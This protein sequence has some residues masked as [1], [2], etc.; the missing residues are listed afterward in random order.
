MKKTTID[1]KK[2]RQLIVKYVKQNGKEKPVLIPMEPSVLNK[3][4][5]EKHKFCHEIEE[6]LPMIDF[7]NVPFDGFDAFMQDFK[8]LTGVKINPQRLLNK[9]L[10]FAT[11]EG[12][13]FTGSFEDVQMEY[14]DFTNSIGA[15]FDPKEVH[16][17]SLVGTTCSSVEF[18]GDFKGVNIQGASF[19][20]STNAKINLNDICQNRLHNTVLCGAQLTG[21]IKEHQIPNIASL[22]GTNYEELIDFK[23]LTRK[24]KKAL[25]MDELCKYYRTERKHLIATDGEVKGITERRIIHPLVTIAMAARRLQNHQSLTVYKN[26]KKSPVTFRTRLEKLIN[27]NTIPKEDIIPKGTK[28]P[29]IFSITHTG[30]YDIEMANEAIKS[31][32]FLL[33]DDEE[34]MH[35]TVDGFFTNMNGVVYVDN[36]YPEDAYV[37]K[38]TNKK[39]LSKNGYIMWFPERIWNL[40]PNKIILD[41]KTGII[42]AAHET[43]ALILPIGI[44]QRDKEFH[45]NI[46][47]FIDSRE[48][49]TTDG[50][51]TKENKINEVNKLRDKMATL[52]FQLWENNPETF[53]DIVEEY[54][55]LYPEASRESIVADYYENFVKE[56]IAEWP[57]ITK[58]DIDKMVFKPK[59]IVTEEEVFAPIRSV[60]KKDTFAAK[61]KK[62]VKENSPKQ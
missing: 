15:K 49:E 42:E 55:I 39:I 23:K 11:C 60:Q 53:D 12:V 18:T 5:F 22:I 9:D 50:I 17:K 46:G 52:K 28:R 4:L 24:E 2:I 30:K 31:A 62:K 61:V 35:R 19:D 51:L 57:F 10:R 44:D 16:S 38:E 40:S 41:C 21:V 25:S 58:E 33:S 43:D 48:F 54:R 45:I 20:G 32:Y 47:D 7:S 8:E 34:Y 36:D 3:V 29:I 26:G 56:R 1:K 37:A 27:R 59:N 14:A 6:V 13:E